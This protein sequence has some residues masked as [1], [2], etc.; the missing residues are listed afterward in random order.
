[1]L[2]PGLRVLLGIAFAAV[3]ADKLVA[4]GGDLVLRL[5][6]LIPLARGLRRVLEPTTQAVHDAGVGTV[7]VLI[8]AAVITHANRNWKD[9]QR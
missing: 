4:G 8:A 5:L 3:G 6:A 2:N 9:R 1:V 7:T